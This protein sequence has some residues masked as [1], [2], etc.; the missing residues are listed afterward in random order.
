MLDQEGKQFDGGDAR[1]TPAQQQ[2]WLHHSTWLDKD[3]NDTGEIDTEIA[4]S[5]E[6]D[7]ETDEGTAHLLKVR[8]SMGKN[9]DAS[10]L[11]LGKQNKLKQMV[12]RNA[13]RPNAPKAV[14]LLANVRM[15][16]GNSAKTLT[17]IWRLDQQPGSLETSTQHFPDLL[18][19]CKAIN[20]IGQMT[21]RELVY[22]QTKNCKFI[23]L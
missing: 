13:S 5:E 9:K 23:P 7:D 22:L 3:Q 16:T 14:H 8:E 1:K 18:L 19:Q 21:S 4:A 2:S 20:S 12:L 15:Q 11:S 17:V 10:I 6:A